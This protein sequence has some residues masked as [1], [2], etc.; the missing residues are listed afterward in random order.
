MEAGIAMFFSQPSRFVTHMIY[1]PE[2]EVPDIDGPMVCESFRD[3]AESAGAMD[4]W[5]PKELAYL[6][7]TICGHIAT[8]PRQIEEGAHGLSP[9]GIRGLSL[10]PTAHHHITAF[11]SLGHHE[12]RLH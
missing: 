6:S 3:I 10:L 11:S 2:F 1:M 4:G 7:P 8:M 5:H 12:A 9:P